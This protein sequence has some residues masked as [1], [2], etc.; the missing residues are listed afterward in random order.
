MDISNDSCVSQVQKSVIYYGAIG[1]GGMEDGKVCVARGGA[2]EICMG[3]RAGM[4]GDSIGG[5]EL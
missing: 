3:K 5:S 2:I 1:G 4:E